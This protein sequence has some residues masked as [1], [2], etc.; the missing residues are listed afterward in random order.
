MFDNVHIFALYGHLSKSS[1]KD[2]KVGQKIYSGEE[3]ATVGNETEK[4]RMA[5]SCSLSIIPD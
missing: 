5:P 4:R 2:K 3:I 1:L